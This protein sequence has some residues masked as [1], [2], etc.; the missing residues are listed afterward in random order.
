MEL[1]EKEA[2]FA[3]YWR[4][5]VGCFSLPN[6]EGIEILD[7]QRIGKFPIWKYEY[8]ELKSLEDITDEHAIQ[9]ANFLSIQKLDFSVIGKSVESC[10]VSFYCAKYGTCNLYGDLSFG[11]FYESQFE[12]EYT[13]LP[14]VVD[15]LRANGYALSW[16]NS[17]G[18]TYTVEELVKEG[19]IRIRKKE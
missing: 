7:Q 9:V 19:V 14:K 18:R 1:K 11:G 12:G 15:F 10:I 16:T 5:N 17:E 2:F 13:R 3:L 6:S 8:L 4:Q